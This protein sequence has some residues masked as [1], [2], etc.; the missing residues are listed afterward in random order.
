[1][2]FQIA[3]Y[4]TDE[5]N[6]EKIVLPVAEVTAKSVDQ[7]RMIAARKLPEDVDLKNVTVVAVPF[8]A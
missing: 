7:A 6:N 5:N 1:M 8:G 2:I 3:A 4:Q